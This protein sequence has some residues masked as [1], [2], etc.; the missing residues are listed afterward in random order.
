[1]AAISFMML[2]IFWL[3][4]MVSAYAALAAARFP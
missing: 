4:A 1:V 3:W 2:P